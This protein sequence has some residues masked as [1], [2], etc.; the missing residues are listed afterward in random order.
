MEWLCLGSICWEGQGPPEIDR[1]HLRGTKSQ[2]QHKCLWKKTFPI[3]EVILYAVQFW[4]LWLSPQTK[5]L[6]LV[7]TLVEEGVEIKSRGSSP[8]GTTRPLGTSSKTVTDGR[9]HVPCTRGCGWDPGKGCGGSQYIGGLRRVGLYR[10]HV[11]G[12]LPYCA[13]DSERIRALKYG[14]SWHEAIHTYR[15]ERWEGIGLIHP[16]MP[17]VGKE[18]PTQYPSLSCIDSRALTG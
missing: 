5:S 4:L 10:R 14:L 11:C 9:E 13:R 18:Q 6:V 2:A 17:G 3:G 1:A 12:Y 8:G 7:W 16:G 15:L